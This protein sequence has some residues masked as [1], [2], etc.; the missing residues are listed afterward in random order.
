MAEENTIQASAAG[1]AQSLLGEMSSQPSSSAIATSQQME[2]MMKLLRD[3]NPDDQSKTRTAMAYRSG[4]SFL[5]RF[6]ILNLSAA[7]QWIKRVL[8]NRRNLT[9][10][11]SVLA[12]I[13]LL[14]FS[15][16]ANISNNG[17][18]PKSGIMASFSIGSSKDTTMYYNSKKGEEDKAL[19]LVGSY[20]GKS[21]I[22]FLVTNNPKDVEDL[23]VALRSLAFLQGDKSLLSPVLVFNEDNLSHDQIEAIRTGTNRPIS[24]PTVDLTTFPPGFNPDDFVN[25]AQHFD[26]TD[27]KPWGYYQMIRFFLT[28]IWH[29]PAVERYETIMRLDSDSCFKAPNSYLPRMMYDHVDYHSQYVG[30]EPVAGRPY[31]EGLFDF[32]VEY[33][34]R[35]QKSPG[36]VMLWHFIET[37]WKLGETLPVLR[38]N[39]EISKKSYMLRADVQKWHN[40]LTEEEPYGLFRFRWGDA[41]VRFLEASVFATDSN[42]LMIRH[43]GYFHK[44]ECSMAEVQ[45]ALKQHRLL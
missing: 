44:R 31:L 19:P 30:V 6:Q 37:T 22:C 45:T 23:L 32:T 4:R 2:E 12:M 41:I 34:D 11:G 38:T 10:I 7:F 9:V 13:T 21:V 18:S 28:T 5:S 33:M 25:Q 27:R 43:E 14:T 39:L 24:F 1:V 17:G 40:T 29:H 8:G 20:D 36:N 16:V 35:V 15:G 3:I 26:V 42:V